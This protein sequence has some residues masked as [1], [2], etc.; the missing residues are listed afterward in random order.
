M[1]DMIYKLRVGDIP[2]AEFSNE[3]NKL[4]ILFEN[5]L[6]E[7]QIDLFHKLLDCVNDTAAV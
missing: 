2:A 5:L 6:S 3:F 4:C 1:I 7:E